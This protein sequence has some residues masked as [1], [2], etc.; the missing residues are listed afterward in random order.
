MHMTG[1]KQL[2]LMPLNEPIQDNKGKDNRFIVLSLFW[3]FVF[4]P[5]KPLS[6]SN[7]GIDHHDAC[8]IGFCISH[9][10]ASP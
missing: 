5:A 2:F 9:Q 1:I 4:A 3:T 7:Y 10:T 6:V 8:Q